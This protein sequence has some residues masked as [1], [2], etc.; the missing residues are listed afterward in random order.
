MK[1]KCEVEKPENH[2][3]K[4]VR[5]IMVRN[6]DNVKSYEEKLKNLSMSENVG[7]Q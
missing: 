5:K 1:R 3:R 2:N 6:R 4:T 7:K